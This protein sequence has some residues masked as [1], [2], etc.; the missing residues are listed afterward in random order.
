MNLTS[1]ELLRY[2]RHLNLPEFETSHQQKLKDAKVLVVGT[3][4]L[5]APLLQYLVAAGVGTIGLIDYDVIDISNLQRQ[6][7]FSTEDI[8]KSKTEVASEKLKALNPNINVLVYD[9]KLDSSNAMDIVAEFDVVADGTDNFPTRYLVNDACVLLKKVNVHASVFRFQ[10][11]VSVFN[12]PLKDGKRG[13][14]YRDL[15]AS[16]PPPEM[17]SSCAEGGVL[18]V[19]PGIMG[20]FQALEVI[21]VITGIGEVLSGKLLIIDTLTMNNNLLKFSKNPDNPVSGDNPSITQLID[22]EE[23]CG[24]TAQKESPSE[25]DVSTLHD[26]SNKNSE[27]FQLIDVRETH[28]YEAGNINGETIPLSV[29]ETMID[30]ISQDKKVVIHCKSGARSKKAISLLQKKYKFGNLYN[31]KGGILAWKDKYAPDLVVI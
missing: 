2:S 4:G 3:G 15:F 24:H 14:D 6:V 20:S 28:E 27:E 31:L 10:G 17:V 1:S 22:Y 8:G 9:E 18:G 12:M 23:F 26:W 25:I 13:P 30:H 29:L 16:P 11:Q 7:L 5:G 19:L 21:K